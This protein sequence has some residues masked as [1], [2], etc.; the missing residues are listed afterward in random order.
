ML[1]REEGWGYNNGQPDIWEKADTGKGR[2][3][4]NTISD[5]YQADEL[6]QFYRGI[7][8]DPMGLGKT[9]TMIA[10]VSTDVDTGFNPRDM[11]DHNKIY[12]SATLV[13]M[14]PPLL[15]SWEEQISEHVADGS[16][17]CRRHH[18][19]TKSASLDELDHVDI[20]LTTYHTVSTEFRS[21]SFS[22]KSI[23][24][25]VCWRRIVLDEARWAV[26]GTPIYNRLGGL[27]PLL[28]FIRVNPYDDPQ[29]FDTDISQFWKSGQDQ[30]AIQRLQR[31][32]SCLLL[33]RAK[34]ITD[35]PPRRDFLLSVQV[36]HEERAV[37]DRLREQTINKVDE[38]LNRDHEA[39]EAR[40][41]VNV[42]QQIESLRLFCNLGLQYHSRPE[43]TLGSS[44]WSK[45]AQSIFNSQ[46][47]M[48]SMICTQCAFIVDVGESLLDDATTYREQLYFS[49]S[50]IIC[51]ECLSDNRRSGQKPVCGH[52]PTCPAANVFIGG[53]V[54]EKLSDLVHHQTEPQPN[55]AS[56]P[57]K[58]EALIKD[59]K[60]VP[61]SIKW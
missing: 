13:I 22:G 43:I 47:E 25:Q 17:M 32:S 26:T 21:E 53:T 8:A 58:I 51:A 2:M 9:L 48:Q 1:P 56:L 61:S 27:V 3:F 40:G 42:V 28:N 16:L 45:V 54:V 14:P 49:C 15:G 11:V 12:T 29:R 38:A 10:L 34:G 36:T 57:S 31:L 7:I 59:L 20:V 44:D 24:F 30:T 60:T 52:R 46:I 41:Y 5:A 39:S 6:P 4:I 23:L 55:L 50:R 19:Q 33:R 35:L 37:Y 18:G